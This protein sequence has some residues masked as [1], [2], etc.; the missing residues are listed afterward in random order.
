VLR[1]TRDRNVPLVN[2]R[3]ALEYIREQFP[4]TEHPLLTH[5]FMTYGKNVFIDHLGSTI[6]ASQYGQTAMREVLDK[7]L[8]R[9]ERDDHGM[10]IQIYPINTESLAINPV[11]ASGQPV[12]KGT[13]VMAATLAA[14]SKAGESLKDLVKDYSLTRQQIEQAITEFAA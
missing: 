6:N 12:V 11:V 4:G 9:I 1:A 10:P 14:R 13:R 7:Y 8:R 5:E 2:V 3:R